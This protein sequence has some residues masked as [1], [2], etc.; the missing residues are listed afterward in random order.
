MHCHQLQVPIGE[1]S[2]SLEIGKM[3]RLA[4]GSVLLKCHDTVLLATACAQKSSLLEADFF[5]F[6]VDYQEKFSAAG[7]TLSGFVK[8]EG[9]PSERETLISR[10]IDRPIRPLFPEGY[11]DEVQLLACVFSYDPMAPSEPLAICAASAALMI[12]DIPFYKPVGGVRV[13]MI[14]GEFVINPSVEEMKFSS[15]DLLLAGTEDAILMIEGYSYFLSENQILAAIEKGHESIRSI[16]RLLSEWQKNVGKKKEQAFLVTPSEEL[17]RSVEEYASAKFCEIYSS[18][19]QKALRQ[20]ALSL[21]GES[22]LETFVSLDDAGRTKHLV[23]M[24][25]KD[26]FA[27]LFRKL[28]V[29]TKRREDGRGFC[30]IRPISIDLSVLPRAH[31]SALFTR[32]ETQSLSVCT[33]GGASM[34]QRFESLDIADGVRTF[35]LQ[36]N[37]LPF[38]VGEVSS[39][40]S[41]GRREIGHG[42]LAERALC[43]LL[44]KEREKFPYTIRLESNIMESNG[45]SSMAS[46]CGGCLA[47][48]DAGV[49]IKNPVSGIA[50]GLFEEK[51]EVVIL[52]DISGSEDAFGDMDLK[53]S[54]SVDG[55]TAFQMDLKIEGIS[56]DIMKRAFDQAREGRIEILRTMLRCCPESRSDLSPY[57]PRIETIVIKPSKIALVIG[58]GG[59]VIRSII[60]ESG[61]GID[62]SDDGFINI[63]ATNVES[64]KKAKALILDVTADIKIGGSYRGS[65]LSIHPFGIF[66]RLPGRKD[67]L[68]PISEYCHERIQSLQD[69]VKEGD[70]VMVKVIDINDR[71][72]IKL[73][74]R[75]LLQ[76]K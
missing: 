12:S 23:K 9:R 3:A 25:S 14:Q 69:R 2:F 67:G 31:G 40:R 49:P 15:L 41:P 27:R 55:I 13:G 36:Y 68:C 38:S 30:D 8:R 42:C 73:S 57:A 61:A 28:L 53:V 64:L 51:G 48:M 18:G 22:I 26:V 74:R 32:G 66:V 62:V 50:M 72:Q 6:R 43:A 10:L 7:K 59:K 33:L 16:C 39:L 65:V 4:N 44:P 34:G 75:A 21:L 54:G 35:Y 45:S 58:S 20:E 19:L 52:S 60:E 11:I 5:L 29:T 63:S 17:V 56:M 24:A 47:L 71:G 46:V 1:K 70:E 76:R 37:F